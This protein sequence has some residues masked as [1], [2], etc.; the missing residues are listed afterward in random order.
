MEP[1]PETSEALDELGRVGD[2]DIAHELTR[3]GRIAKQIVPSCVG[4]SLGFLDDG[5]TFTL[6]ATSE[7][8][9]MLDAVQYLDGGPCVD[10]A[11][12]GE[13]MDIGPDELLDEDRW[14]I[15]ARASAAAGVASSLTLPLQ[16]QSR[17]LG[18]INLYAAEP[19]AFE[20][21]QERL[22]EALGASAEHAVTNAD[23]SFSTRLAAARAPGVIGDQRDVDIAVGLLSMTQDVSIA[24]ARERLRAAA[25][26]AG[27]TEGQAA[28]AI[29]QVLA[30]F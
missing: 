5:V 23:L 26:R 12:A 30:D 20:G 19:D 27:V 18:T 29:R 2:T 28:R 4:L 17:V 25:A 3:M 9:A 6:Q 1:T 8:M 11:I 7:E 24:A 22:A 14:A 10:A 16:G 13:A 15:Y 21:K